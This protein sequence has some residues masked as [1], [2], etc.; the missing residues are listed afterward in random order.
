VVRAGSAV[1]GAVRERVVATARRRL[2]GCGRRSRHRLRV[3]RS[4][5]GRGC[6]RRWRRSRRWWIHRS[7]TCARRGRT[8][9]SA[10]VCAGSATRRARERSVGAT[11]PGWR[12]LM[13]CRGP[14]RRR[15]VRRDDPTVM[16]TRTAPAR[17]RR[18]VRAENRLLGERH[19]RHRETGTQH[20]CESQGHSTAHHRTPPRIGD[21]R[22]REDPHIDSETYA[23][24]VRRRTTA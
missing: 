13:R 18:S 23:A 5:S 2:P 1:V 16:R 6:H 8:G 20:R 11:H 9:D 14:R 22:E 15:S 4:R 3:R 7:R 17:T 21:T 19:V 24:M 10:V 12:G